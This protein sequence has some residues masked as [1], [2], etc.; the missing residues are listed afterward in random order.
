[1]IRHEPLWPFQARWE[2]ISAGVVTAILPT[3]LVFLALQRYIYNGFTKGI[4]R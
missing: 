2:V 3:L 1:M 4:T